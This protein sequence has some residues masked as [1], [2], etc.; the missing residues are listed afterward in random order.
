MKYLIQHQPYVYTLKA[1]YNGLTTTFNIRFAENPITA[2]SV[3]VVLNA[4]VDGYSHFENDSVEN[5]QYILNYIVLNGEITSVKHNGKT[6]DG[7]IPIPVVN[8]AF[9]DNYAFDKWQSG[10]TEIS[11][12]E[13]YVLNTAEKRKTVQ[14]TAVLKQKTS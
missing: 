8:D 4:D 14:I 12:I 11:D 9:K 7:T 3:E 10:S 1:E 13:Q 2:K 6:V 5:S